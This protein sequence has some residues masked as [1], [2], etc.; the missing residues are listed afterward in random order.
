MSSNDRR[1]RAKAEAAELAAEAAGPSF[2]SLRKARENGTATPSMLD[3]LAAAEGARA[4]KRKLAREAAAHAAGHAADCGHGPSAQR[5]AA[6][7]AAFLVLAADA[8]GRLAAE[9]SAAREAAELAAAELALKVTEGVAALPL[10]IGARRRMDGAA[11]VALCRQATR[12]ALSAGARATLAGL[13]AEAKAERREDLAA[14]LAAWAMSAGLSFPL[15][16]VATAVDGSG[17][18]PGRRVLA[19]LAVA[20]R[21]AAEAEARLASGAGPLWA[22]APCTA[23]ELHTYG[24][25]RSGYRAAWLASLKREAWRILTAE[26]R[27][28]LARRERLST[29]EARAGLAAAESRRKAADAEAE[30]RKLA[31]TYGLGK[32][33]REAVLLAV[34]DLTRRDL[35]RA[36]GVSLETVKSNVKRGRAALAERW[37]TLAEL[38]RDWAA[39]RAEARAEAEA[40][41][42]AKLKANGVAPER[43]AAVWAAAEWIRRAAWRMRVNGRPTDP[44]GLK[45]APLAA[46]GRP[47]DVL[48][49][50]AD[51]ER[52]EAEAADV[53][54]W[55]A[56]LTGPDVDLAA[57]ELGPDVATVRRAR[58]AD[59]WLAE[60][61]KRS[62]RKAAAERRAAAE[63]LSAEAEAARAWRSPLTAA[64]AAMA[65]A[66]AP[67]LAAERAARMAAA[68]ARRA[69]WQAAATLAPLQAA[70]AAREARAYPSSYTVN[71]LPATGR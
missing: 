18:A 34:S 66:E 68:E 4:G 65:E 12:E 38:E 14:E 61:R 36:R 55:R 57:A 37:P 17:A 46:T 2:T 43:A 24:R 3:T 50:I 39:A 29:P 20:E 27:A 11:L 59:A 28:A 5:E 35:A 64:W 30:A 15:H 31:H 47:A 32:A 44:R 23:A 49:W 69:A 51:V 42:E 16:D 22:A 10:S 8:S 45:L 19:Y 6:A 62:A 71:V 48:A 33:E 26:R 70:R 41:A 52:A 56:M 54:T 63:R 40:T 58:P 60:A 67:A 13:P 7:R 1:N 21:R 9:G 53:L 25:G